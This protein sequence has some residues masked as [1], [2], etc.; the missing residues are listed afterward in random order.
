MQEK[1]LFSAF[2][3]T[4]YSRLLLATVKRT[5]NLLVS[6]YLL[7]ICVCSTITYADIEHYNA[8]GIRHM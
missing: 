8:K 2:D 1:S 3:V 7:I 4:Q 6:I 5:E